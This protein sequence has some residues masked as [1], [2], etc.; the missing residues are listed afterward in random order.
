[1]KTISKTLGIGV[2]TFLFQ[3]NSAQAQTQEARQ[4]ALNIQKLKQ[5][6]DGLS[7]VRESYQIL[8][9]G[10]N[11][12]RN[13]SKQD[14][15]LH[16]GYLDGLLNVSPAVRNYHRVSLIIQYQ[17]SLVKEYQSAN[18]RWSGTNVFRPSELEYMGKVYGK[19]LT[20]SGNNLNEL[21]MILTSG[22]TRMSD[23]ERLKA[24]DRIYFDMESKLG[25]LREFNASTTVLALQRQRAAKDIESVQ[26]LYGIK[27]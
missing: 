22:K 10:Y 7:R 3:F 4:L 9:N 23:D 12:I 16:K 17:H 5:M 15:Q 6:K 21:T 2:L 19:L 18:K 27:F 24:I 14:F 20:E 8:S 11:R 26:S 1:M 25:F 13:L